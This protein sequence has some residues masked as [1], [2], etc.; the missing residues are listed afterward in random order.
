[1]D[2]QFLLSSDFYTLEVVYPDAYRFLTQANLLREREYLQR[3]VKEPHTKWQRD[4]LRELDLWYADTM[5]PTC[6]PHKPPRHP[7]DNPKG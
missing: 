3:A 1:M 4:R 7:K 5:K 6:W 2:T